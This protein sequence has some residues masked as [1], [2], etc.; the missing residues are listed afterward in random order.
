M[1]A[2]GRLWPNDFSAQRQLSPVTSSKPDGLKS[3]HRGHERPQNR[4][5]PPV[6]GLSGFGKE[7]RP[8]E[9]DHFVL[10]RQIIRILDQPFI[11]MARRTLNDEIWWKADL[12]TTSLGCEFR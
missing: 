3:T 2:I 5:V 10:F 6:T 4:C 8:G 11:Q 7:S 1:S 9:I 12:Q